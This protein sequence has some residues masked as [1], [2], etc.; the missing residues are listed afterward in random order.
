MKPYKT[1]NPGQPFS[2]S[3][4]EK[5]IANRTVLAA[6][7]NK[8]SYDNGIISEE[9]IIWLAERA[10][11]GFGI[12]TTAATN[13]SA[14]GQGW[15]GEFGVYDDIHIADLEKLTTTIHQTDSIILAQLFHGGIRS[16]QKLTGVVPVS[17][18]ELSCDESETG[19]CRSA[20][21]HDIDNIINN[22]TKAAMRCVKSGF[23]GIELHGAHGYLI[24]Q[25][26]G[27][28]T[29]LRQDNWGG[30]LEQ[31]ARFLIE[32][33]ESIK[34][35][36]PESF[37]IGVRI[38]PEI[39]S[40]G[41]NLNDTIELVGILKKTD[42][43]FIHLS[44]W[45]AF[46]SSNTIPQDNRTLTE[47]ITNSYTNLPA[48]IST[49]GVWSSQDAQNVLEQGADLVGVGRVAIAHP[50]WGNN[51]SNI[52]Y[53]P[54]RPPFTTQHLQKAKLSKIFIDYMRHWNGFVKSDNK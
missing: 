15:E 9:E 2:F 42:I 7:T 36:V 29:N 49:G 1:S 44:C 17:A 43:D 19:K 8:Q 10:K 18:S 25:F 31:R 46:A 50:N 28:K 45:D 3:R 47:I 41:I 32:I 54:D 6:M 14:E 30:D 34:K 4:T 23:D 48:I 27:T 37:I 13:V 21:E 52:N 40:I 33:Y 35:N 22:F 53:N 5:K 39:D 38:S 24:S 11:G 51:I 26:L 16:P 20:S 12:I